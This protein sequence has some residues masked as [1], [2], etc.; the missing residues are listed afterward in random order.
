MSPRGGAD[1]ATDERRLRPREESEDDPLGRWVDCLF[2]GTAEGVLLGLPAL[3]FAVFW[4]DLAAASAAMGAAVALSVGVGAHR[5]GRFTV[6]PER[7]PMEPAFVLLRV[8]WYN[9]TYVAAALAGG[10]AARHPLSPAELVV[11]GFVGGGVAAVAAVAFPV[12]VAAVEAS[13]RL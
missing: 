12:A 7:P 9:A 3:L 6:A 13:R 2:D 4:S 8:L 11:S 5:S 1:S 10:A